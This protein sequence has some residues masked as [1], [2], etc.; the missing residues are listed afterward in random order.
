MFGHVKNGVNVPLLTIRETGFGPDLRQRWT[1]DIPASAL[2]E[3]GRW[4]PR[5]E[6]AIS[7]IM[8]Q[9][10]WVL[11][12]YERGDLGV[13]GLHLTLV[14][15]SQVVSRPSGRLHPVRNVDLL[16]GVIE[17]GLYRVCADPK[18]VAYL[19]VRRPRCDSAEDLNLPWSQR[20]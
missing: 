4:P 10:G 1:W 7:G 13:G 20:D 19:V 8:R 6:R 14:G 15:F 17:V 5:R 18:L 12:R 3:S 16:K 11:W 9:P 2:G